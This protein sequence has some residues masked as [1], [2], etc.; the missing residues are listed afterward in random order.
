LLKIYINIIAIVLLLSGCTSKNLL[1]DSKQLNSKLEQ[2]NN[3][4]EKVHKNYSY[5]YRLAPHDRVQVIVYKHKELNTP[6]RGAL[7]DSRGVINLPLVGAI[8]LR[9]LTQTQASNRIKTAYGKY[10]RQPSVNLEVLNKKAYII[11]EVR[12]Q[13]A[14]PL[15]N[16]QM[17]LLQAIATR[18]GF[19]D[20]ANKEK[21]VIIRK[22]DF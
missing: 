4:K 21:L 16:D 19:N 7:L 20:N 2:K 6:S 11:G 9:G 18:G 14:L 3:Q 8:S 10:L 15:E 5:E 1:Q 22:D 13:G 17:P 12:S